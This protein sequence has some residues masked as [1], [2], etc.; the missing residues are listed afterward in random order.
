V[1]ETLEAAAA[2]ETMEEA[3]VTGDLK[4]PKR[5]PFSFTTKRK[6]LCKAYLYIMKV[7]EELSEWPERH[8]RK[9]SW[10]SID[11]AVKLCKW[12]WMKD[13]LC[14]LK[15]EELAAKGVELVG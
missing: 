6:S 9:R 10:Y 12:D 8:E 7:N 1:D 2:R 14:T 4:G 15:E 11:D 3:G 5:G 13:A